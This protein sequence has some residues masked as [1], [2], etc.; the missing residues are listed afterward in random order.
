MRLPSILLE[1]I[2][3]SHYAILSYF[4]KFDLDLAYYRIRNRCRELQLTQLWNCNIIFPGYKWCDFPSLPKKLRWRYE[5]RCTDTLDNHIL[6]KGHRSSFKGGKEASQQVPCHVIHRRPVTL[7]TKEMQGAVTMGTFILLFSGNCA[8]VSHCTLSSAT[9]R[10]PDFCSP[11]QQMWLW[12][13]SL[14]IILSS[15][16]APWLQL[17]TIMRP[18]NRYYCQ[19]PYIHSAFVKMGSIE[20]KKGSKDS[21]GKANSFVPS[22]LNCS[23]DSCPLYLSIFR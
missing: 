9:S 2:E 16:K 12:E 4:D 19:N 17:M 5:S 18:N 13:C 21:P 11:W 15:W 20:T 3:S 1:Q 10:L 14:S 6:L 7:M 22:H 8:P 23:Y